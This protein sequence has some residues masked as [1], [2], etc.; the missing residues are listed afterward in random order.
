MAARSISLESPR[1]VESDDV[2]FRVALPVRPIF[3]ISLN[4]QDGAEAYHW[5]ALAELSRMTSSLSASHF[6]FARY[7]VSH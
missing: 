7:F 1:R 2:T 4:I 6:R 5:K 3:R